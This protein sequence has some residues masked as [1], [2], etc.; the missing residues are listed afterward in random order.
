MKEKSAISLIIEL[1][2]PA[3]FIGIGAFLITRGALVNLYHFVIFIALPI[4]FVILTLLY[5]AAESGVVRVLISILIVPL[6]IVMLILAIFNGSEFLRSYDGEELKAKYNAAREETDFLPAL[7][8]IGNSEKTEYYS[9]HKIMGSMFICDSYTLIAEYG[10]EEYLNQKAMIEE[11][12]EFVTEAD[13]GNL[14]D[15]EYTCLPYADID[16]FHF[17]RLKDKED[18]SF[19]DAYPKKVH[20][21]GVNDETFEIVYMYFYDFDLDVITSLDSFINGD[22]GWKYISRRHTNKTFDFGKI[23]DFI[24]EKLPN[25]DAA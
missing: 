22:C 6:V 21:I 18:A 19:Y 5:R 20:L 16:G 11:K 25:G 8:E 23:A 9:F 14:G 10:E 15:D 3:I 12:Y 24:K 13:S 4:L 17:R 1:L 2:F 7:D